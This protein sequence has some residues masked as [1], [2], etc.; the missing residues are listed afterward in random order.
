MCDP[1]TVE[2]IVLRHAD[3]WAHT[4]INTSRKL[5][6]DRHIRRISRRVTIPRERL[7]DVLHIYR[8]CG[9][10]PPEIVARAEAGDELARAALERYEDRL[11]CGLAPV[12]NVLDPGVVVLGGGVSNIAS[13][14]PNVSRL[15][16]RSR[17]G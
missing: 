11:A 17:T 10:P 8:L 2:S 3:D 5:K 12:I 14:Y 9:W 7:R 1:E 13:L 4:L 15:W 6:A 16:G